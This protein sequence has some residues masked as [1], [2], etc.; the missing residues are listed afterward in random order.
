MVPTIR[1][2]AKQTETPKASERIDRKRWGS[3]PWDGEPDRAEWRD[4]ATGLPCLAQRIDM[5]TWCGYVAVPPEHRMHPHNAAARVAAR[6]RLE[7]DPDADPDDWL[8]VH[9]GI[10]YGSMC[11]GLICHVPEPGES[12]DVFWFGFDCAHFRDMIPDAL[13]THRGGETTY[14]TLEF[15]KAECAKLAAQLGAVPK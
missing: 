9:G 1:S 11:H 4:A 14:R 8:E 7:K 6:E 10:T 2:Q 12:D 5:G 3:G 15:V 13:L